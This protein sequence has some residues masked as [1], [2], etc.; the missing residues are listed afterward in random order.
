M[1][2]TSS[3]PVVNTRLDALAAWAARTLGSGLLELEPLC[4]DAGTRRYF[5]I[6]SAPTPC[7]AVEFPA[8]REELARYV[9][10]AER[11][12]T[13]GLNVPEI[14]GSDPQQG[15]LLVSDLGERLYLDELRGETVERLY[16]DALGA[17]VT[18][19]T[20][21]FTEVPGE[22]FLPDYGET[23][24]RS[25]LQVFREWYVARHLGLILN[26]SE[27][28]ALADVF[29]FLVRS[30]REQPQV[31]THR[32]FH[33]R[34]LLVTGRNN[35]GIVDFQDAVLGPAT[36]DLVSLL[37]D[38]YIAWPREQVEEWVKGYHDLCIQSG[39]PVCEDDWRFLRWFDLMGVQRH[40]KAVGIFARLAQREGR[41][42]YL[43]E[44]P[45]TLGYA[46]DVSARYAE[47]APLARF[48]E[49]WTRQGE[50][51]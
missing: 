23:L 5:R 27:E 19:Q 18:L 26:G 29:G 49:A 43:A 13:L 16:G 1:P 15:F 25:E 50:G 22:R 38:C 30:A 7:L 33:S 42:S 45:R 8:G 40:L 11:L 35:P 51:P 47:L 44:I 31:W 24:L 9:R 48:L 14:L 34:N 10:I 17:L 37:R 2:A 39:I 12:R 32:D 4:S 28:Q 20:G 6:R 3:K 36:Y 41:P 46:S 21:T